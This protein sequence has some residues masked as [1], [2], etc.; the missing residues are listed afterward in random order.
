MRQKQLRQIARLQS[1]AQ[2]YFKQKRQN[3]EEWLNTVRG[4]AGHAAILAFLVRY[5]DPRVGEP[6]SS[7]CER[8]T[9]STAWKECC[10]EIAS[11]WLQ[12]RSG[13]FRPYSSD[14]VGT[15]GDLV[16]HFVIAWFP[17][18]DEKDKLS[19]AFSAAPPWLL[20]FTFA[21]YTA[22]LLGLSLPDLS[23]VSRFARSKE[24]FDIWWGL[25]TGAFE[26]ELWPRGPELHPLSRTDLNL[27][28]PTMDNSSRQMTRRELMRQR[29][30]FERSNH[31]ECQEHWPDI[32]PAQIFKL[33]RMEF[34]S[35]I[36]VNRDF[37]H[38]TI[39]QPN[40]R[41]RRP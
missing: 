8:C 28:H 21:D 36:P 35:L 3:D 6:L 37:H 2:P 17:G 33:S 5:G 31:D 26:H 30:A 22:A 16:R 24:N 13:E 15:M 23:S 9:A 34:L 25:P 10:Q 4:A 38:A 29:V 40:A 41:F 1:L 11:W 39:G 27:L 19:I 12:Y 7:A 14:A 18:A 20:W 32:L